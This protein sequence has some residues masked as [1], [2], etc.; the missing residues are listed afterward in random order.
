MFGVE[1]PAC[2]V[3]LPES[4]VELPDRGVDGRSSVIFGLDFA[5]VPVLAEIGQDV[6][7]HVLDFTSA[8]MPG[9][10][11]DDVVSALDCSCF[12]READ[13]NDDIETFIFLSSMSEGSRTPGG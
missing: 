6:L 1:P 12:G 10:S 2:G 9:L 13:T 7:I 11:G 8:T 4:G 5:C 3:E